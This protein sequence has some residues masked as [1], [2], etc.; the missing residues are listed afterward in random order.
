MK[1]CEEQYILSYAKVSFLWQELQ[2]L[3]I[4]FP[5]PPQRALVCRKNRD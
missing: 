3:L 4:K 2:K 5:F 1:I